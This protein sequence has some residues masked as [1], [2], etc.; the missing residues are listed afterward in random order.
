MVSTSFSTRR[1]WT[2]PTSSRPTE[3]GFFLDAG[4]HHLDGKLAT[5]YARSRHGPG[6]SDYERAR[7]QQQILL[8]LRSKLNDPR[9]FTNLPG[10]LYVLSNIIR[11]D[12]PL[13]RLPEIVSIAL[14][15]ATAEPTRIVLSPPR[16]ADRAFNSSGEATTATVLNM[17]AI[18]ELSRELFGSDSRYVVPTGN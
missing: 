4:P 14:A 1:S 13:D 16:Y 6:N 10:L 7:R 17:D 5:A 18:A 2:P 15:S 11:T 9:L 12:A 8:A 3:T